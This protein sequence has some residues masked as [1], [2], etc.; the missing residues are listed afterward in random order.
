MTTATLGIIVG[1]IV[2]VGFGATILIT[3]LA[4][5][6]Y[7]PLV[8]EKYLGKLFALVVV[9]LVGAGFWLFDATFQ[10]PEVTFQPQLPT[11]VYVFGRD[12]E[13]VDR[14]ELLLGDSTERTFNE[15]KV[16]FDVPRKLELTP[17]GEALLVKSR[18]TDHQLG[19]IR[20]NDLSQEIIDKATSIDRHLALGKYYAEC[21]DFPKCKKRRDLS[22]AVFHL[23]WVLQSDQ[24]NFT[25]QKSATVKLFHL[26]RDLHSCETFLLLVDKI[27]KY[28]PKENRYPEIGDVY[29]TMCSSAHLNF[30]QCKTVYRQ[31][32]KYLLRF[33]SLH[34]VNPGTDLFERVVKQAADLAQYL[35][36]VDLTP[37]LDKVNDELSSKPEDQKFRPFPARLKNRLGVTSDKIEET[38]QCSA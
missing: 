1:W 13:P 33:L 8:K 17:N 4:L 11:E 10:P 19:T 34:S 18:R 15:T 28:R 21:L 37:L 29:Q 35:G 2:V 22:Q 25:Q 14:T 6:G 36:L 7:L 16:T 31:S 3:L 24:S 27:K 9:E 5:T 12:G 20:I 32:L 30:G 26:Q 38:F 23:T